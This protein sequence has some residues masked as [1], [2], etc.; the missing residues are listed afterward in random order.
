MSVSTVIFDLGGVLVDWNPRY[1]YRQLF[2]DEAEMERFLATVCTQEWNEQQDAGRP[3]ADAVQLLSERHPEHATLIRAYDERW[4]EMVSGA[5]ADSVRILTEL[6]ATDVR[7][8][9]LTNWSAEK[10]P[11]AR[12]RFDFLDLFEGI[13]VSGD[14]GTRKP[15]QRIYEV[16]FERYQ[17]DPAD[18]V[19]I[20][21][22]APNV[23]MGRQLGLHALHFR[24]ADTLRA[25]L[26]AVGLL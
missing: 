3:F 24:G 14:E 7:L 6:S 20:D 9:A 18:A 21:D 2:A 1:L 19:F 11:I 13:V 15:F 4:G 25:D 23:D 5:L 10:F 8:L 17:V 26:V 16:L 12:E 22:S